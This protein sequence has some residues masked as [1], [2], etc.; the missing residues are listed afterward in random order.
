MPDLN[1]EIMG[2]EAT[3]HAA[4]PLLTFQL[5]VTNTPADEEIH[6]VMLQCQI[7]IE[8]IRRQ[9]N[10]SEKAK[11]LDLFGEPERWGQTLRTML[12]THASTAIRGFSGQKIVEIP[13]PCTYDLNVA[14]TK[15]FYA[16]E[17]GEV[18]LRFLFSGTVFYAGQSS[19]LQVAQISW[20]KEATFRMPVKV[21]QDM[22]EKYYPNSAWLYLHKDVFDRLY[23]YKTQRGLPTWEE[24]LESLLPPEEA[25]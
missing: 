3:A 8:S 4:T 14:G 15:Y 20:D 12:W 7:Q 9:Y 5:K 13:V 10:G 19:S 16:L 6:T 1:F 11:L 17:E 2:V 21:W 23:R 18:P 24:T 22:I 25:E